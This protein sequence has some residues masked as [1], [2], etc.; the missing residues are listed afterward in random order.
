MRP[1]P[2]AARGPTLVAFDVSAGMLAHARVAAD[3]TGRHPCRSCRPTFVNC[4]S[5]TA[6]STWHSRRSG[7]FPSWRTPLWRWVRWP[8]CC[9]LLRA[10]CSGDPSDALGVRG[11]S[12]SRRLTAIQSYF[13]R[14]PYVEVDEEGV[15]AYVEHHRTMGDRI[16]EIVAPAWCCWMC[17][18]R[19]GRRVSP[20][21]WGQWSPERGE[22][23]PGTAIFVTQVARPDCRRAGRRRIRVVSPDRLADPDVPEHDHPCLPPP[24]ARLAAA[25]LG[26]RRRSCARA[27]SDPPSRAAPQLA[28]HRPFLVREDQQHHDVHD[29]HEHHQHPPPRVAGPADY[30]DIG[31]EEDHPEGHAEQ[32][33]CRA[34]VLIR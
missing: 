4:P 30:L 3:R 16:R 1:L 15:P 10:G 31:D 20:A 9:A 27:G 13:D 12:R 26:R 7:G 17:W 21:P 8:G 6:V 18:N 25:L 23:F 28:L 29:R 14:A 11:R 24:V 2:G 19:S 34:L 32:S 22:I 5:G 33:G